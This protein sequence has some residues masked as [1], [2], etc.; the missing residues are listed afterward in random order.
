MSDVS[1]RLLRARVNAIAETLDAAS[2]S[3]REQRVHRSTVEEFNS[4][5]ESVATM[6]PA[7]R[8]SLPSYMAVPRTGGSLL[9]TFLDMKM[10]YAQL[11]TVLDAIEAES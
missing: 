7:Y 3:E 11:L 10:K 2:Q 5:R 6:F 8:K 1:P 9:P 4:I